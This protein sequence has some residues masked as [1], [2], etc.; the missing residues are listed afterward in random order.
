MEASSAGH[1]RRTGIVPLD[2]ENEQDVEAVADIHLAHFPEGIEARCGKRFVTRFYYSTMIRAGL[3]GCTVAHREGRVVAY[4]SYTRFPRR[5]FKMLAVRQPIRL[6]LHLARAGLTRFDALKAI[7]L[8]ARAH[9]ARHCGGR[10]S[11]YPGG[12]WRGV[13]DG[14][15]AGTSV[16]DPAGW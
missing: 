3:L 11:T 12:M 16:M 6:A 5:L 10:H 7:F 2:I 1:D 8:H 13:T 14:N 4:I 9:D 15:P